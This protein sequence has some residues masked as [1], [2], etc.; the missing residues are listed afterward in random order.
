VLNWFNASPQTRDP[1]ADGGGGHAFLREPVMSLESG[2]ALLHGF[3]RGDMGAAE[4]FWRVFAPKL[5]AVA[6][7]LL[8]PRRIDMA[9]DVVQRVMLDVLRL[10]ASRIREVRDVGAFLAVATRNTTFN[11]SRGENREVL[12]IREAA[13]RAH[14]DQR[15]CEVQPTAWSKY[16]DEI[17]ALETL[18]D[19]HREILVLRHCAGLS[20]D[21]LAVTLGEARST[22]SSR[23]ARAAKLL[24]EQ[25]A[26]AA[27]ARV[28]SPTLPPAPTQAPARTKAN[29]VQTRIVGGTS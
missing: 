18:S 27:S 13:R 2:A 17:A 5:L 26:R 23:Y 28:P 21:Q 1:Q 9:H 22:L 4:E 24:D 20:F 14:Q 8:G 3:R 12:R 15:Q 11:M 16:D 10:P 29:T 19:E 7:G 6:R 25:L